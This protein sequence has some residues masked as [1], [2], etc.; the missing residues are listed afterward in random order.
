MTFEITRL[1]IHKGMALIYLNALVIAWNQWPALCGENGLVPAKNFV[2]LFSFR[3]GPSLLF[4]R[5]SDRFA[6]GMIALGIILSLFALSGYSE[7]F[8]LFASMLTWMMLWVIYASIANAS[9]PFYGFGWEILLLEAGFLTVFLGSNDVA[10][11][12]IVI[13]LYRW[14]LFRL[15]F[16]AGLIK[17]RGD[18]C[19]R[20]LTALYWHHETQPF[21]NPL[22]RFFHHLPRWM[23]RGGVL[24]NHWVELIV[25]FFLF[26]PGPVG[27]IAG[28]FILLFQFA[29]IIGGNLAWLNWISIVIAF[30]CFDDAFFASIF[31]V[32]PMVAPDTNWTL[33]VL[34]ALYMMVVAF[35]SINPIRNLLS[36]RQAM[37]TSFDPFNLVNTYGAFGSI[38]KVRNEIIIEGTDADDPTEDDWQKYE[39][40]GKPGDVERMPPFASPYYYK[41]DWQMW[42]A[43]MGPAEMSPWFAGLM[44]KIL[45]ADVKT[46]K[47]LRKDPFD[48][49]RPKQVRA[50]LYTYKFV[51]RGDRSGWWK[52]DL[53]GRYY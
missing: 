11:P 32:S 15:M 7:K 46:L 5:D 34:S 45:Q 10:T 18:A 44:Q 52:R 40:R 51:P 14:L 4:W 39:F 38:T 47:L 30:S 3:D 48:G 35:L 2:R 33:F 36:S 21:P 27:W 9:H 17:L 12:V 6:K 22:S 1:F 25:P 50:M 49:K 28:G 43:A 42:F 20:D 16:G 31:G 29:L 8:G 37:N 24:F 53:V 26:I 13:W 19:W 23:C 41:L